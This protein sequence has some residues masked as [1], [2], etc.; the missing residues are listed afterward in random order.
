VRHYKTKHSDRELPEG[1][2]A[3]MPNMSQE[4]LNA[5]LSQ[6]GTTSCSL[7]GSGNA[8]NLTGEQGDSDDTQDF[9]VRFIRL[10]E[11]WQLQK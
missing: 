1:L 4:E 9:E 2:L 6:L 5:A 3:S 8:L 10:Y 11:L 7:D